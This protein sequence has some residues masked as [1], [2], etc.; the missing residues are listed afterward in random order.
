MTRSCS[1]LRRSEIAGFEHGEGETNEGLGW[2]E[3]LE[4]AMVLRLKGKGNRWREDE[5]GRGPNTRTCPVPALEEWLAIARIEHGP[6][7]RRLSTNGKRV[8]SERLGDQ[9]VAGL[10][11]R[12]AI[13]AGS[14][15]PAA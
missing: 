2:P 3:F 7:F 15:T 1:S 8:L 10:V 4:R 11:K 6:L 12:T 9:H 14:V 5:I 13:A